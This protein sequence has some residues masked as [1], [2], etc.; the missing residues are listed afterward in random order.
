METNKN[1]LIAMQVIKD[2]CIKHGKCEN[3]PAPLWVRYGGPNCSGRS[4]E[5]QNLSLTSSRRRFARQGI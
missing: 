1:L 5:W 3:R 4:Q 2:E